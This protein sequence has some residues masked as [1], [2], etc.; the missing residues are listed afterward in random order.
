MYPR[1]LHLSNQNIKFGSS[2]PKEHLEENFLNGFE[3]Y[4][5]FSS[6]DK[7]PNL[8]VF[9][10]ASSLACSIARLLASRSQSWDVSFALVD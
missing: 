10:L 9:K 4:V 7:F 8:N 2:S 3:K 5:P 6:L 1:I